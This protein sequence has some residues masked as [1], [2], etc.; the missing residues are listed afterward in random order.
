MSSG[1]MDYSSSLPSRSCLAGARGSTAHL[2]QLEGP[3]QGWFPCTSG[4][5]V[6]STNMWGWECVERGIGMGETC[7]GTQQSGAPHVYRPQGV[8][9][10]LLEPSK[11]FSQFFA[12]KAFKVC[13]VLILMKTES[14]E[15][16]GSLESGLISPPD[17][18]SASG[19]AILQL[20]NSW[21]KGCFAFL[22]F[23]WQLPPKEKKTTPALPLP[24]SGL[25][26]SE[27]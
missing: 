27:G 14:A 21:S 19:K 20:Q 24:F 25:C 2:V 22:C 26:T 8:H 3:G 13:D 1:K 12:L 23:G 10:L 18:W 5:W 4:P 9:G 17:T 6:V 15:C 7:E 11:A 16:R